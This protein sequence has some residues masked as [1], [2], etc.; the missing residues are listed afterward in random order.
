MAHLHTPSDGFEPLS[1]Q[2]KDIK[3]P[4]DLSKSPD[5]VV[6]HVT[7]AISLDYDRESDEGNLTSGVKGIST[8][9]NL[10]KTTVADGTHGIRTVAGRTRLFSD[11]ERVLDNSDSERRRLYHVE[12]RYD[13]LE[14]ELEIERGDARSVCSTWCLVPMRLL[15]NTKVRDILFVY[16]L[17]GVSPGSLCILLSRHS[18]GL[19]VSLS[20]MCSNLRPMAQ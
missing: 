14:A 3:D 5:V 17:F 15:F 13:A 16:V 12:K 8:S 20:A 6:T 1:T 18:L 4:V 9:R 11:D 10:S 7:Q 2:E 19:L